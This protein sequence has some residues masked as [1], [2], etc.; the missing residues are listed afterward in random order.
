MRSS[1]CLP[2]SNLQLVDTVLVDRMKIL[3]F[4]SAIFVQMNF[5][6]PGNFQF[7]DL[8]LDGLCRAINHLTQAISAA[9]VRECNLYN[10]RVLLSAH[11]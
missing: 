10:A 9:Q 5:H 7:N 8:S 6:F 1:S 3:V 2:T 4:V 11:L